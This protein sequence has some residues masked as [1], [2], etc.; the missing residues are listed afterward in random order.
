MNVSKAASK[1]VAIQIMNC[2]VTFT[3]ESLVT[4]MR[5]EGLP[6]TTLPDLM[7]IF[8]DTQ[9]DWELWAVARVC[10]LEAHESRV[11]LRR[12]SAC[13]RDLNDRFGDI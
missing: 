8:V 6:I 3:Y 10:A 5:N 1:R 11:L 9:R 7:R 2:G 13:T 12:M 4:I